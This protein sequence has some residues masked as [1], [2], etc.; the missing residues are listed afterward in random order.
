MSFQFD[1]CGDHLALDF[2]NTLTSRHTAAP[3]ERLVDYA[4]LL[5][6]SRQSGVMDGP[7]AAGLARRAA[8]QREEA[9]RVVEAARTLREALYRLFAAVA[10]GADP[11]GADLSRL[12]AELGRLRVRPDLELGYHDAAHSLDGFL[13]AVVLAAMQLATRP[14]LRARVRICEAPDCLWLFFDASRNRSRRWC[15]MRQ[16]GNRMKARRYYARAQNR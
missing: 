2:A 12:D 6:F 3:I 16:C 9:D 15:D 14:E 1:L 7:R 13:G 11:D 5:D 10:S 8:R 4:T